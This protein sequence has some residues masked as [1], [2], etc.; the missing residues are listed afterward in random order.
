MN[1]LL[2][3]IHRASSWFKELTFNGYLVLIL[4]VKNEIEIRPLFT[5]FITHEMGFSIPLPPSYS[6]CKI[7]VTHEMV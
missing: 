1:N 2:E 7:L 6:S 3:E 5:I 4:K